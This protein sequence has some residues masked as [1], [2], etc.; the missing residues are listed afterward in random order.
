MRTPAETVQ[1]ATPDGVCPTAIFHPDDGGP[2]PAVIA[3]M[4][5]FGVRPALFDL[6]GRIAA[7]GYLVALPDLFYRV[8]PY[9]LGAVRKMVLDEATRRAWRERFYA[10]AAD[11]AHVEMDT[12]ALLA[13]LAARTDVVQP[14][15]GTTGYCMGG[16]ISLRA[17]ALFPERIAACASF[18]GGF[19][20]TGA[21]DSPHRL[22][23]RIR[24][25]VYVAGA[26]KDPS[27]TD[28]DKR[29]L[30]EALAAAG[31]DYRIETWPGALH[32]WVPSDSPSHHAEA[33]ERHYA[34]LLAF[35]DE[36][37]RA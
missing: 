28:D 13:H 37:L 33:S 34:T 10:T 30:D 18:H 5:G 11:P 22:A 12:G 2:W 29:T 6:A 31:V 16:N 35:F 36:T 32:G 14:R 15:V 7:H 24:G 25:R 4:D 17:A 3:Y 1:L 19:L 26:V 23:P 8:A 9:D 21:P 20:V 27:F